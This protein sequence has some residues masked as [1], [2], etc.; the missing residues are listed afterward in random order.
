MC[1]FLPYTIHFNVEKEK[2]NDHRPVSR[3]RP[4]SRLGSVDYDDGPT[5][6]LFAEHEATI[7]PIATSA[8][9]IEAEEFFGLPSNKSVLSLRSLVPNEPLSPAWGRTSY[10]QPRSRAESPPPV[11]ILKHGRPRLPR[12]RTLKNHPTILSESR[13]ES[14]ERALRDADWTVE[15]AEQGNGGLKNAINAATQ[16]GLLK[17][18]TWVSVETIRN[19][20]GENTL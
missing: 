3:A 1:R 14:H 9:A 2:E 20:S 16:A 12:E 10:F 13:E 5:P 8:A 11:S 17:E 6:S 18:N 19:I 4:H 7:S 15:P